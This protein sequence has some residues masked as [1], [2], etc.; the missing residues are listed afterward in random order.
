M[1]LLGTPPHEAIQPSS[2]YEPGQ[3]LPLSLVVDFFAINTRS[4][5]FLDQGNP[6]ECVDIQ[7]QLVDTKAT[8]QPSPCL[9]IPTQSSPS[10]PALTIPI[11]SKH[12]KHHKDAL[13]K[14][15]EE[16]SLEVQASDDSEAEDSI[17]HRCK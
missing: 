9:P 16:F 6:A 14:I 13:K 7:E 12:I 15:E 4:P 1:D 2:T 10:Q 17:R 5:I 11:R 8:L 3:P